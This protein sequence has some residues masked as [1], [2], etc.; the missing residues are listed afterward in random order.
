MKAVV[1]VTII[2]S[3]QLIPRGLIHTLITIVDNPYD[4]WINPVM[5]ME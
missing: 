1:C 5:E 4:L 3:E 2:S